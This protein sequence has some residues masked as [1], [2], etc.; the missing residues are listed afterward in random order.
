M[1]ILLSISTLP[2]SLTFTFI[3]VSKPDILFTWSRLIKQCLHE[4]NE[5]RDGDNCFMDYEQGS[6]EWH[7]TSYVDHR[8]QDIHLT[9][10]DLNDG[11]TIE[12]NYRRVSSSLWFSINSLFSEQRIKPMKLRRTVDFSPFSIH[13][14]N[15]SFNVMETSL[16]I[17]T[18]SL[19]HEHMLGKLIWLKVALL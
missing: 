7:N 13:V 4:L 17:E 18:V 11:N 15:I 19:L 1:P 10:F 12:R 9:L 5:R 6:G 2:S 16:T 14:K 3:T 8:Y